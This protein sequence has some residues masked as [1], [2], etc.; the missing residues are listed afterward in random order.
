MLLMG[1]F[2]P[3]GGFPPEERDALPGLGVRHHRPPLGVARG[4][5]PAGGAVQAD[6]LRVERSKEKTLR[7][8]A[9]LRRH[10]PTRGGGPRVCRHGV[11]DAA[12]A[13]APMLL[14]KRSTL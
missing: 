11:E 8:P 5:Y 7:A 13:A 14:L 9:G 1:C 2:P 3:S 10:R 4:A 12:A 6:L